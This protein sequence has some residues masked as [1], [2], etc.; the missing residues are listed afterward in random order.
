MAP[1][2]RTGA[3]Y[4]AF[5]AG[6]AALV[7]FMV[8]YF[9]RIG[10]TG[11]QI[12]VLT[13]LMPAFILLAGPLWSAV[14]DARDRTR[15]ILVAAALGAAA[16][17]LVVPLANTFWPLFGLVGALAFFASP[18]AA[19]IDASV[20]AVLGDARSR[21]GRLR[22]W[23]AVGWGVSAP[24]VGFLTQSA[25]VAWAFLVFGIL[26]TIT[27]GVSAGMPP[28]RAG[29]REQRGIGEL[30]RMFTN[31]TWAPFLLAAFA[32][33]VAMTGTSTFLYLRFAELGASD[34]LVG[35]AISI[36]TVS[37]IPV[38]VGTAWLVRRWKP[39][40]LLL[41][42]LGVFVVR[43]VAYAA[44]DAPLALASIQLLHGA[45]FALMWAAGVHR[46]AELAPA[47][48]GTTSQ[49]VFNATVAG[50]GATCGS[51]LG[52]VLYD[53]LGASGMFLAFAALV[54]LAAVPSAWR[55]YRTADGARLGSG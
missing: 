12:G 54:L 7:P 43:L 32:G 41:A 18:L 34:G 8:L 16:C 9:E 6:L 24:L 3:L 29:P 22:S 46:A 53:A 51:L 39:Q 11:G 28:V 44:L 19:L 20:L 40:T 30:V 37:E 31:G 1:T 14:A 4:F 36:A 27:A 55:T 5:Y 17:A 10:L 23:G 13:G 52:G 50:L 15:G 38:F 2:R 33:G 42:A 26:M 48:R 21:Y 35:I 45:S 25:G 49:G 47:G